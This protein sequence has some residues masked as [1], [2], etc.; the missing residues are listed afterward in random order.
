V[1]VKQIGRCEES[2][3]LFSK[4]D[5]AIRAPVIANI[6]RLDTVETNE[7]GNLRRKPVFLPFIKGD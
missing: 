2:A 1:S 6:E 3:L 4:D 5:K 7:R